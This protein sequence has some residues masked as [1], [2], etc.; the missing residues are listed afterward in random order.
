[1]NYKIILKEDLSG[2][3]RD[4]IFDKGPLFAE[5]GGTESLDIK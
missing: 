1:M 2:F 4:L 5:F 3:K